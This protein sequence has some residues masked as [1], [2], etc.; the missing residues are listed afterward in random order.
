MQVQ[1]VMCFMVLVEYLQTIQNASIE[2][3]MQETR[4]D[5]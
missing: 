1:R 2:A 5:P 3:I 4:P